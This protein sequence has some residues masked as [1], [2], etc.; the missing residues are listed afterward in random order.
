MGATAA[1]DAAGESEER[2]VKLAV[3][4]GFVLPP[5]EGLDGVTVTDRGD[6]RLRAVYWDT[7][8]LALAHAGVGPR[9]RNGVWTYKGRSRRQGDAVVRKE[10]EEQGAAAA[11]IPDDLRS[12]VRR[13]VDPDALHPVAELDTLRRPVDVV[14]GPWGVEV[15]HDRVTILDGAREVSTFEE[16]EVEFDAASQRLADHVVELLRNAGAVVDATS[17][18]MRALRALGH[19]PPEVST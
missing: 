19:D 13:W 18:Y 15:V 3:P 11:A 1:G 4:D 10:A 17:K 5:L 7:D 9:H 2:E 12:R 6:G 14:D 16:V 8:D